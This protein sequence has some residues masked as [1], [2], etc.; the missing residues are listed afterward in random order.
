[1]IVYVKLTLTAA[2]WGGTFVAG[3]IVAREAGPFSAAFLRFL[4]ASICLLLI[5]WRAEGRLPLPRKNRILP[6]IL[7]GLTGVFSYNVF[8]FMGLERIEAGRASLIIANNPIFITLFSALIFRERLRPLAVLGILLSLSGAVV[9]ITRGNPLSAVQ[10]G[11]GWGEIFIFFCVLSWVAYSL[12]GKTVLTALSPL[13]TVTWA[14]L[15][16][17]VFLAAPAFAEG[18]LPEI[19]RY[20]AGGWAGILYLGVF[21][22]VAGF[23]WYY[24]GIREIGPAR[25]SQFINLVPVSAVLLAALVLEEP[26]TLSLLA[27]GVL[28]LTGITLTNR[29]ASRK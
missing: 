3:R 7:L 6:L 21:G 2:F 16:G 19:F 26:L 9:V 5:T 12:I 10:G 13:V 29:A 24:R 22:T 8:F 1:M 23:V 25:A 17:M 11:V 20:S 27:G 28:V 14:S 18:L 15:L 4:T